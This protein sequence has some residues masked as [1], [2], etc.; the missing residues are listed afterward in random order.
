MNKLLV[1]IPVTTENAAVAERTV[2]LIYKLSG[3]ITNGNCLLVFAHD[4]HEEFVKKVSIA[5]QITFE[6]V[7]FVRAANTGKNT[8]NN[9]FLAAAR[10]II[11]AYRW[12]WLWL[13]PGSVP[14]HGEWLGV[15]SDAYEAQPKRYFGGHLRLNENFIFL[16]R[17]SVYPPGALVELEKFLHPEQAFELD[18]SQVVLAKSTKTKIIQHGNF[19]SESDIESIRPDAVLVCGDQ[20]G[21]LL[22]HAF[23]NVEPAGKK[24]RIRKA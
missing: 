2:D 11:G 21:V 23:A 15:L 7:D 13:E 5:A 8:I 16:G 10:H 3:N 17:T 19:A 18:S 22:E 12:P 1:V 4:L 24:I 6:T 20:S 14:F 9:I